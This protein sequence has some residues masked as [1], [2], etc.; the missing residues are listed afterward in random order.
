MN[1]LTSLGSLILRGLTHQKL[2]FE[3]HYHFRQGNY[4][5][6]IDGK[7]MIDAWKFNFRLFSVIMTYQSTDQLTIK[8]INQQTDRMDHSYTSNRVKMTS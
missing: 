2:S 6:E 1:T 3:G 4:S 7:T 8:P 5:F